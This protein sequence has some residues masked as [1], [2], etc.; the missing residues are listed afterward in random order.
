MCLH[1][2]PTPLVGSGHSAKLHDVLP[3]LSLQ[4]WFREGRA[5]EGLKRWEDAATAYYQAAQLEASVDR[6]TGLQGAFDALQ[7][8]RQLRLPDDSKSFNLLSMI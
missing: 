1:S 7:A 8:A 5:A 4:A 2:S 3:A 6:K